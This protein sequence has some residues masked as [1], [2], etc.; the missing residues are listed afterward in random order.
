MRYLW[1]S[2]TI[3]V[4]SLAIYSLFFHQPRGVQPTP[5]PIASQPP[6]A[7]EVEHA[8]S[9][10]D[11]Q[12]A[13]L[14]DTSSSMDGLIGQARTQLWDI[15]AALQTDDEDRPRTVSVALYQYGN[16]RLDSSDGFIERLSGLTTELDGV[17]VKLHALSTSGG[18][19]YAPTAI[20]R[21]VEEL[22]WSDDDSPE[23]VIVVAGNEGFGQ[24][25][26]SPRDAL[27][28]AASKG[29]KVVPIFCANGGSSSAGLTSWKQ[30][31]ALAQTDLE[32]IDPDRKIAEL[33]TPYDAEIVKKY[34]ELQKTRLTYGEQSYVRE[35]ESVSSAANAY[36]G[37]QSTA[38]QASRAVTQTRQGYRQDL[39]ADYGSKVHLDHLKQEQLPTQ[40]RGLSK[41][42]QV[43]V[44]Q[45]NKAKRENLE[46]EIEGLR[47]K[48]AAARKEMLNEG[49][50][51]AAPSLGSSVSSKLR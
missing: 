41:D 38:V 22:D 45:Q 7:V 47:N 46:K 6:E 13:L 10:S 15:V 4:G 25:K 20:L 50:G 29:I 14:L 39:T 28:R 36:V 1:Y 27:A 51:K 19:E 34:R 9:D 11:V 5:G 3:F 12:I 26:I 48:R 35:V 44:I 37:E 18:K 43:L 23:K 24:G 8:V 42:E 30:A 17:S 2:I 32:T 31:A 49:F 21:A 33:E 40:L 16:S